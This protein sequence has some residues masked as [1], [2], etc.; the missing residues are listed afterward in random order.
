MGGREDYKERRN[1]RIERYNSLS[2]KFDNNLRK[3]IKLNIKGNCYANKK[4]PEKNSKIIYIK[5]SNAIGILKEKLKR[6]ENK[7]IKIKDR[8]HEAW[9]VTSI[10]ANIRETKLR[11][12]RL[13]NKM[14]IYDKENKT[15]EKG[16]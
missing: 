5:D 15:H 8:E 10:G 4:V 12:K 16:E 1:R 9:E 3:P 6:L 2:K 11:I 13:E 14:N 7:R